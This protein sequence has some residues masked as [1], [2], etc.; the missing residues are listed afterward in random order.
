[1]KL[2]HSLRFDAKVRKHFIIPWT[3]IKILNKV[4]NNAL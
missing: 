2:V 3:V 1:M 4:L